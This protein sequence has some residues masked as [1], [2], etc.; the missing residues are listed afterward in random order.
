MAA[1]EDGPMTLDGRAHCMPQRVIERAQML[2]DVSTVCRELG[3]PN[4]S[5][6]PRQGPCILA[7]PPLEGR[8]GTVLSQRAVDAIGGNTRIA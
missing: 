6:D 1:M 5:G 2:G 8:G 4:G 3:N 7:A